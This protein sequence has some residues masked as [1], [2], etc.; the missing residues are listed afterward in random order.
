[1][2]SGDYF[3][4]IAL[5]NEKAKRL[6]SIISEEFCELYSF[7]RKHLKSLLKKYPFIE[8]QF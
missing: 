2:E 1:L 5:F 7:H 6:C 8:E 3:G 4:E